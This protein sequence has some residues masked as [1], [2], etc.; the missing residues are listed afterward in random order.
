M[1]E[2]SPLFLGLFVD[3]FI[4]FSASSKVEDAFATKFGT[5][6]DVDSQGDKKHFLGI[7]F[8]G[9]KDADLVHMSQQSDALKLII[10]AQLDSPATASKPTPYRSGHPVDSVPDIDMPI[11]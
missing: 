4:Y 11:N 3:E 1:E 8:K 5:C 6:F 2:E 9:S 7:N 10:K